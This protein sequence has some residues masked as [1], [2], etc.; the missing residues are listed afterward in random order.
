[1]LRAILSCALKCL[2]Q[3]MGW[4]I[5]MPVN[6]S[7]FNQITHSAIPERRHQLHEQ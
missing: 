4:N 6:V 5:K 3:T 2:S 7:G 1:M